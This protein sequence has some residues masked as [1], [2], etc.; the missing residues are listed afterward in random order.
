[1]SGGR[2]FCCRG[3]SLAG[4]ASSL[5][6]TLAPSTSRATASSHESLG[7]PSERRL[8]SRE[9][10]AGGLRHLHQAV[11]IGLGLLELASKE[12]DLERPAVGGI[13]RVFVRDDL[14]DSVSLELP[15]DPLDEV[16][17]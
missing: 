11:E 3:T 6:V 5:P 8:H 9:E 17:A 14:P 10:S 4:F 2:F 15:L 13:E 7:V 16:A 12:F 1:M